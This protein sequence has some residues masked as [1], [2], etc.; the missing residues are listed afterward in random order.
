M[1]RLI[2]MGTPEFAVPA[3]ERLAGAGY[4]LTVVTQ[5]DR[6]AG[7]GG[8]L[9]APPVK[10]TALARGLPV[11][12]PPTL[13]DPDVVARIRD[14]APAA[15]VVVAYGELLRQSVLDIPPHGC[16]NLHASRLPR[17]RGAIPINAAILAGDTETGVSIILMDRGM[18][19][20][21]LLA[22]EWMQILPRDTTGTL[23]KRLSEQGAALLEKTLPGVLNGAI[24][25]WP[26]PNEDV[27]IC[28]PLRKEDGRL[29]WHAS[30]EYL[31]RQIRAFDPWPGTFTT[32]DRR[33]VKVLAAIPLSDVDILE[34]APGQVRRVSEIAADAPDGAHRLAV[35]CGEGW[36]ELL[37]L[38]LEGKPVRTPGALLAGYPTL[39]SARLE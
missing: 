10:Q 22:Q 15:I 5:P 24:K 19:T 12:Q 4:D 35:R 23:G 2:F 13:R 36:L 27:T 34:Y 31:D 1:E 26:Q 3:L 16:L 29:D 11:W 6:P 28:R 18:D 38:Q 25:P 21:P 14:L 33:R 8:A 17:W 30:A 9:T 39:A 37:Q 32:W 7:R 20:G